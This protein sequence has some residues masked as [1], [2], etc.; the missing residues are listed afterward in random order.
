MSS[1]ILASGSPRRAKLL[2]GAGYEP[3]IVLPET[4]ELDTDYLTAR[5]LTLFNAHRKAL[6]VALRHPDAVV[7][8]ADTVVALGSRILNKPADLEGARRMLRELAGKSHEVV[9]SVSVIQAAQHRVAYDSVFTVVHFK[10]LTED[11]IEA[12][13]A[14]INPLDKAGGYAAQLAG[15]TVIASIEGSFSNVVGLPME[16]VSALLSEFGIEPGAPRDDHAA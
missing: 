3:E 13:L 11:V 2:Q 10:P 12:Y 15:S 7:L 5:E 8:G 1:F 9:T 6:T 4:R 16:M 14:Q